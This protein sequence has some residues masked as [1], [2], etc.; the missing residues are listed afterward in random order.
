MQQNNIETDIKTMEMVRRIRNAQ[1]EQTKHM[2]AEE[3][4]T[5]FEERGQ[6]FLAELMERVEAYKRERIAA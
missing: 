6:S 5:Y 2:D 4:R 3:K 1:Y